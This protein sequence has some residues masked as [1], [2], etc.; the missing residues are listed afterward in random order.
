MD[1]KTVLR[2]FKEKMYSV[3]GRAAEDIINQKVFSL[4]N[5][6]K[7]DDEELRKVEEDIKMALQSRPLYHKKKLKPNGRQSSNRKNG[8]RSNDA[9]RMKHVGQQI[10]NTG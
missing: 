8:D 1:K 9:K 10:V 7:L 4:L 6:S 2:N 5:T 3:Y